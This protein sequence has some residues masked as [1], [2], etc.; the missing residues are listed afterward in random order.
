MSAAVDDMYF[1][2][3][4][5]KMEQQKQYRKRH[6]SDSSDDDVSSPK[7]ASPSMDDDRRA[8]HNELERRRRDHIKDHFVILKDSIPLLEGEKSSRALILKRAVEYITVMQ[9]RLNENQKSMDE[10]RRRNE[11]L[12]EKLLERE[13]S[14]SSPSRIPSLG[15]TQLPM[16]QLTVPVA[17]IQQLPQIAPVP[18]IPQTANPI[19]LSAIDPVQLNNLIASSQDAI[20]ALTQSLFGKMNTTAPS[21]PD[22]VSPPAGLYPLAYSPLD[23]PLAVRF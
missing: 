7:S 21:L 1:L 23:Q 22:S 15:A 16:S 14:S 20:V 10:L 3:S 17:P 8:H 12:E 6:H 4:S 9:T 11:M 2:S 18:Q 5:M 19:A 13:T